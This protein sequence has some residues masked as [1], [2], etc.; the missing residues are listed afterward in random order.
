MSAPTPKGKS[1]VG[2]LTVALDKAAQ[3][4]AA[5]VKCPACSKALALAQVRFLGRLVANVCRFCDHVEER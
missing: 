4:A 3:D 2:T 5:A 1:L